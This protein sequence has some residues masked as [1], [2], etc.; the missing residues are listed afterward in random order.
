MQDRELYRR[1]LGIESPWQVERVEL[2]L[3]A[4]EI[5]VY[6]EHEQD[7]SWACPEC[8][9]PSPLYDHQPER[10][11]RHLDTCQYQTIL[12][13]TSPRTPEPWSEASETAL[14]GS[15]GAI[16]RL[17]RRVGDCLVEGGQPKGVAQQLGLSWDEIHGIM[18]RAV[19]RGLARR[20]GERSRGWE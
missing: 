10:R 16:Y 13:A 11:W 8:L 7:V 12:H 9:A 6:L 14:G 4:G 2:K 18:E 19:Q 5:H 15:R 20:Q 3:E 1:I 17:I